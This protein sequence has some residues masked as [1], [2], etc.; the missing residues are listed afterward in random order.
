MIETMEKLAYNNIRNLC[1]SKSNVMRM[2]RQ[3][4]DFEKIFA[5]DISY[6][7]CYKSMQRNFKLNNKKMNNLIKNWLQT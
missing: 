3:V 7:R 5:K 6:K 2:R 4:T 1:A